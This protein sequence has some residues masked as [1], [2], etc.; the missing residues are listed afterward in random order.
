M[1]RAVL[2]DLG[3]TLAAY[4]GRQEF[5]AILRQSLEAV[6]Q[7]LRASRLPV[8]DADTIRQRAAGENRE[9]A[10]HQVRPLAERLQRIFALDGGDAATNNAICRAFLGPIFACAHLYDDSLPVLRQLRWMGIHTAIVSNTPWGSPADLWREEL[11]RLGLAAAV[12]CSVFCSDV[13]WRKPDR[14]PFEQALSR[15]GLPATECLFVGDDPRWDTIGAL[16][17]GIDAVLIDRTGNMVV[18]DLCLGSLSAVVD[19]VSRP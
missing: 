8:P 19:M 15:L 16:G 6:A 4:Y 11:A 5:P 9:A 1:K 13:G 18:K 7:C 14:R 2:F 12:D 10:D 3:G 17:C